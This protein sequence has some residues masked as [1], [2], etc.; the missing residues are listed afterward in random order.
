MDTKLIIPVKKTV[1][2]KAKRYAE[3]KGQS[4]SGLVEGYLENLTKESFTGNISHGSKV[5]LVL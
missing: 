4:L 1:I 5:L 2:E 3:S